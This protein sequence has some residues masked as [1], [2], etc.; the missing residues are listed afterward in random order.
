MSL[1][2]GIQPPTAD[3]EEDWLNQRYAHIRVPID[4]LPFTWEWEGL[5][6]EW[7]LRWGGQWPHRHRLWTK[8]QAMRKARRLSTLGNFKHEPTPGD[9]EGC[10]KFWPSPRKGS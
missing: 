2:S 1:F 3:N 9:N 7:R 5:Y 6:E 8:L 4:R 10:G